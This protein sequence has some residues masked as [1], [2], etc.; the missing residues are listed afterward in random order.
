[1]NKYLLRPLQQRISTVGVK[2]SEID[3]WIQKWKTFFV[4]GVGRSGTVFLAD[5]LNKS[6][7]AHV[8]HEPVL[9]DFF[10]N[11]PAQYNPDFSLRYIQNFRV[12]EIY[13][14]MK[15]ETPAIYGEVN[16]AI[17][18]HVDALRMTFPGS[19]ILH[20]VRNGRDVVRSHM[21]RRTMTL[22]N[23]LSLMYH[24]VDADPWKPYWHKMDRFARICWYWQEVNKKLRRKI[25][26]TVQFEK[27]LSSFEYLQSEVLES[28]GLQL[29]KSFWEQSLTKP[30]NSTGEFSMPKWE[31]WTVEQKKTF[32]DICE[33]EMIACG[34]KI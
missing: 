17:R 23:P 34:Y 14:R 20:L 18:A 16:G 7:N 1:L 2:Q 21:S 12:K 30:K 3:E 27:I 9:E 6:Q 15:E 31:E 29:E 4:T 32:C 28:C 11:V 13:A 22:K 10:A 25:K 33:E 26:K 24:P 19:P 5:L 8:F